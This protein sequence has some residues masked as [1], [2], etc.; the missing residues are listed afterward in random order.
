MHAASVPEE[1]RVVCVVFAQATGLADDA[2]AANE[3]FTRL[4]A[5][6]E[7]HGGVV[8]K[9]IGDVV[10]AVFG[11]PVAH[12]DDPARAIRAALAL[13]AE[14]RAF[15]AARGAAMDMRAGVNRGEVLY[16]S[17]GG[18]RPTVMGD[19][20]NV[21]RRLQEEAA[22]GEILASGEIAR[23]AGADIV[24]GEPETLRLRGRERPIEVHRVERER[25][26]GTVVREAAKGLPMVGRA[27]ELDRLLGALEGG[28]GGFF[29]VEGEAGSGK[30]RLL[31]EF[32]R[33]ARER[34]AR[35]WVTAGRALE[36][37]HLPLGAFGEALRSAAP[38][39]SALRAWV[40]DGLGEEAGSLAPHLVLSSI[41]EEAPDDRA[42]DLPPDARQRETARA[43]AR[44][45]HR[46]AAEGPAV[47][48]L[49]DL[50][51]A[52]A[53]TPA[54]MEDLAPAL[55]EAPVV[56]LA[57]SRPGGPAPAGFERIFLSPLAREDAALLA[58]RALRRPAAPALGEFLFSQAGGHPFYVLELARWL[59][60]QGLL[61]G[62]PAALAAP[63][64]R[65]PDGLHG[66][67]VAR[68]DAL[69][70]AEK[71]TLKSASA[72]GGAV[73]A[74][75]LSAATGRDVRADL[76][77]CRRRSL[78]VL[79]GTSLVPGD[80]EYAWSHALLRDAAYAL[81]PRKDRLRL[82][83]AIAGRLED[84]VPRGGRRVRALAAG[85]RAQAGDAPAAAALWLASARE[86]LQDA[87]GLEA[88]EYAREASR[89]APGV[90][91]RLIAARA[92]TGLCRH[93][94][95]LEEGRAA[96]GIPGLV[97]VDAA[98][99]RILLS[100][101][102][103]RRGAFEEALSEAD[104]ALA[105]GAGG[106]LRAEAAWCRGSALFR[107][108]RLADALKAYEA[109][110]A[111][112]ALPRAPGEPAPERDFPARL[113]NALGLIRL[114]DGR[115]P[116]AQAHLENALRLQREL[117]S[118]RGVM[119][120]LSNIGII[121]NRL[122]D[123]EG[124]LRA[125]GE[126]L[127][128]A[129]Y[130]GDRQQEGAILNNIGNSQF[131]LRDLDA[132]WRSW[133]ESHRIRGELGDLAGSISTASNLALV[134]SRRGEHEASL[135]LYQ[136]SADTARR[137]GSRALLADPIQGRG[138]VLRGMG[139][140]DEALEAFAEATAIQREVGNRSGLQPALSS[141]AWCLRAVGRLR[142]ARAASEESLALTREQNDRTVLAFRLQEL[143]TIC[144]D[145]DDDAT[146]A[147]LYDEADVA[148]ADVR[149]APAAAFAA[150]LVASNLAARG[151][152]QEA[153][154]RLGGICDRAEKE[155]W[156]SE[157]LEAMTVRARVCVDAGLPESARRAREALCAARECGSALFTAVA[158][159][160]V[161]RAEP[162]AAAA[163]DLAAMAGAYPSS[164][165]PLALAQFREQEAVAWLELGDR[166]RA[167]LAAGEA[168]EF[169]RARGLPVSETRLR[170]FLARCGG[171]AGESD[172]P[173]LS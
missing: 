16:G 93:A 107:L 45:L 78:L 52:D 62:D 80:E 14:T 23:A 75:L 95:A 101:V 172:N 102:H 28:R 57:T 162:S 20:V 141:L 10:M 112:A 7:R 76:E 43:W 92:L 108:G 117:G 77:S 113:E 154:V 3:L 1:R 70:P 73:W 51:W 89:S 79:R 131:F 68:L 171:Q 157:R 144:G 143:G 81:L 140:F 106:G 63:P 39:G 8:D 116:E 99:A 30:T 122:G 146:A 24:F 125:Y 148:M 167:R 90:E 33:R 96:A 164:A 170:A 61:A 109:A 115:Y 85:Q 160:A 128:L 123:Y 4:R 124:A 88:L 169:A 100:V 150:I 53:G 120:T 119:V 34:H 155:G 50:Q 32:R 22:P 29:V 98:R 38:A 137:V 67:L 5:V 41:G 118:R 56:L 168:L 173:V 159:V 9:F 46:R 2:A 114:Y 163:A 35:A 47:L 142:E 145:M 151:R 84:L 152:A 105:L 25:E 166:V 18:D 121:R 48:C 11:A 36:G 94:E 74:E 86:A 129:L 83:G 103:E 132:A 54:L 66:L 42:R 19:P 13:V 37:A 87:S 27:A 59:D 147:G 135:K 60:E 110:G 133:S 97:T 136:E 134:H 161:A 158:A 26:G 65:L 6:V 126:A 31:A 55:A 139:R 149:D 91:P 12:A 71:E 130:A 72:A 156:M 111:A 138:I 15:A 127:P 21:A 64:T 49:E 58:E 153:V 165:G 104:V 44:L 69:P 82:H 17:V 40:A